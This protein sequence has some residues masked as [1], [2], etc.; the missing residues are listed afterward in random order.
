MLNEVLCMVVFAV[1]SCVTGHFVNEKLLQDWQNDIDSITNRIN[2]SFNI[3]DA[4]DTNVDTEIKRIES[5]ISANKPNIADFE[6]KITDIENAIKALEK[7]LMGEK[8][9]DA[10]LKDKSELLKQAVF[11]KVKELTE[12]IDNLHVSVKD[13]VKNFS[14]MISSVN[15][16]AHANIDTN[17][18]VVY[19]GIGSACTSNG[20]ECL[21]MNSDCRNGRCQCSLGM[22]F[23]SRNRICL[24]RCNKYG[25]TFQSVEQRI[26]RNFNNHTVTFVTLA[27]CKQLC[28]NETK[29]ICRSFDYFPDRKSCYLSE[30][31]KGDIT[32][33]WEYNTAGNHFQRDCA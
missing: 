23:D 22:S 18:A 9:E 5:L 13:T 14:N 25:N 6:D 29:F 24:Y 12:V 26:I 17:G 21:V 4:L 27:A 33:E 8:K 2:N 31:I 20:E 11:G 15:E 7:F 16:T 1:V 28:I 19:G 3:I 32:N 30:V 10:V